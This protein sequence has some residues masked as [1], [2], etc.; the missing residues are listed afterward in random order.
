MAE[1][2]LLARVRE[3]E[4]N[5]GTLLVSSPVVGLADSR[6]DE[7]IF[8]NAL[9]RVLTVKVLGERY[10]LRLPRDRHGRV[11]AALI[12]NALTPVEFDQ[13]L[14]RIDPRALEA[15]EGVA[16]VAAGAAAAGEDPASNLVTITS[17]SDG[18]FYRRPSPD[19]PPYVDEGTEVGPGT[20]LGLVEVM[21]CFNQITYGGA[22]YPLKGKITKVMVGDSEEISYGHPL[23]KVMPL[24]E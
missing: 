10:V 15:A 17:P 12:P 8:L 11:V 4:E 21:K 20:V 6:P 16:G 13:P 2:T 24:G 3:D 9:D 18:I 23:F 7:K 19:A 5:P 1:K 22:Q 14:L